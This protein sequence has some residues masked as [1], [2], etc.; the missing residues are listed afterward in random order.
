MR[1]ISVGVS[2]VFQ[3]LEL[4]TPNSYRIEQALQVGQKWEWRPLALCNNWNEAH[5]AMHAVQAEFGDEMLKRESL[6]R[7]MEKNIG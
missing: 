4:D 5:G 2:R 1:V 6:M 7:R 3:I